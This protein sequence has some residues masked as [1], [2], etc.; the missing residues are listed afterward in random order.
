MLLF[1]TG[2]LAGVFVGVWMIDKR[3]F[4]YGNL[5]AAHFM[6]AWAASNVTALMI[7]LDRN[8]R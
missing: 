6:M 5:A 4:T 7:H 8:A 2:I 3:G 1:W